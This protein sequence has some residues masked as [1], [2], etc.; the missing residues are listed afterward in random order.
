M[1]HR[2]NEERLRQLK[3]LKLSF[4]LDNIYN[5]AHQNAKKQFSE[6]N[7][8]SQKLMD[9]RPRKRL[10]GR[11]QQVAQFL[12]YKMMI[13]MLVVIIMIKIVTTAI[14]IIN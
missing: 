10:V 3:H 13:T 14:I 5:Y 9:L 2:E 6:Y 1:D 7:K 12:N 11:F 8:K 4:I